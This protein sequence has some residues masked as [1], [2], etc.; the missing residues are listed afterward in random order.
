[1]PS[2]SPARAMELVGPGARIVAGA[3]CGT[4]ETL[5]AHL[6]AR[7]EGVPGL[8][9]MTGLQLGRHPFLE[10]VA[11]GHLR[12]TT[13]HVTAPV[14]PLVASG[15][16]EYL[17]A[18]L[19][20]LPRLFERWALDVALV[21]VS[22]PD[23]DGF[24]S[25]GPSVSYPR[26]AVLAAKTVIAEVDETTPRT[27][28]ESAV[29]VSRF[30]ALV[31]SETPAPL[32][33][34]ARPNATSRAIAERVLELLPR[35]PVLQLGIG[36]I[37]E[38]LAA[39]LEHATL[40]TVRFVGLATDGMVRLFDAGVLDRGAVV[41]DPAVAAAELMGTRVLLDFAHDN[42]A[43]GVYPSTSNHD[44][45]ALGSRAN[46]VSINSAVEVDLTGQVGSETI[47]GEEAA[48]V[49]GSFDYFE[50]AYFSPGGLRVVALPSTADGNRVSRIV[51]RLAAGTAV[52]IPRHT[53]DVVVT[54]HGVARLSGRSTRE[55]AEQLLA[56]AHPDHRDRLAAELT[57]GLRPT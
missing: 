56:V 9:L 6:A 55:R 24:C 27:H 41:P 16:A 22:P 26:P 12:Y 2:I 18:R 39:E 51:A 8:H 35:D 57:V 42:P 31:D 45:R 37:P 25:L 29:P 21:R 5:L 3:G 15:A 48:A 46:F 47:A 23:A 38:A 40:G 19:S 1:M 28:G 43:I 44:S 33:E 49:G 10:A 32:H 53:V 17:P 20:D 14:R 36:A 4:P 50:A 54:E 30:A 13:W 34:P 7:A 11:E 52:T